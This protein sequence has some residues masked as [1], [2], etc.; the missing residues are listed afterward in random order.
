MNMSLPRDGARLGALALVAAAFGC[1]SDDD[2]S[3]SRPYA[4]LP[5]IAG[6]QQ[7]SFQACDTLDETCRSRIFATMICLRHMPDAVM[8]PVRVLTSAQQLAEFQAGFSEDADDAAN[9]LA[10][11][12][13]LQLL[14]LAEK[15]ELSPDNQAQVFVDTTAAYYDHTT[16][17]VTLTAQEGDEPRDLESETLTLSHEFVHALQDQDVGLAGFFEGTDTFDDYLGRTSLVEGEATMQEAFV[18]AAIWGFPDNPD[19]RE[20]FTYWLTRTSDEMQA[21]SPLL[22]A[23]R[24][25]PYTYGSRFVYN[26]YE[27]GGL[28]EVRARFQEPP[29]S[30][31]PIL[32]SVDQ[33]DEPALESFEGLAA[34]S[35]LDGFEQLGSDTLGPWVLHTFLERLLPGLQNADVVDAWRGDRL[36]VYSTRDTG[37]T[38]AALWTLR[39]ADSTGASKLETLLRDRQQAFPLSAHAFYSRKDRDLT[40]GVSEDSRALPDWSASLDVA[41]Q[42][43]GQGALP[44]A[45][46]APARSRLAEIARRLR[47]R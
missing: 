38:V 12:R 6:C 35:P 14:Q 21:S 1:H 37:E 34:P 43:W 2:A 36:L 26:V 33:L 7:Q 42:S 17:V 13:A 18:S 8:P 39:F 29:H 10:M 46:P 25:I 30:V 11:E 32:L 19:F 27:H 16:G 22:I 47:R 23:P 9:N 20:H 24:F 3:D 15:G 40:I 45:A 4:T 28:D 31:L 44:S 5:V 41:Q